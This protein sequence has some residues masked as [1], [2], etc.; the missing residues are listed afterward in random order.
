MESLSVPVMM[1]D[2][3][4]D[5]A[6]INT[7]SETDPT[8]INKAI[9]DVLELFSRS[10]YVAFTATPFANIFIDHGVE[11]DLFP[12]DFVYSLEAPTN[13]VGSAQTF[14]TTEAVKPTA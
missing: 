9:R 8:A 5:Y 14:G 4:S 11:N 1:L 6:S 13:Y 3:E 2:D 7:N 12:R 10:S